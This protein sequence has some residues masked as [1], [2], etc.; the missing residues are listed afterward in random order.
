MVGKHQTNGCLLKGVRAGNGWEVMREFPRV[1]VM[2][3]ILV[4]H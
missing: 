4:G 2:F 3:Y 1:M